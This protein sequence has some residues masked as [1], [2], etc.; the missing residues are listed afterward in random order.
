MSTDHKITIRNANRAVESPSAPGT[1]RQRR[2][3]ATPQLTDHGT[4]EEITK[5]LGVG[6]SDGLLGSNV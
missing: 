1:R 5:F 6:P 4:V 3:Y 2:P